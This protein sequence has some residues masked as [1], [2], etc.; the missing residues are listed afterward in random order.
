MDRLPIQFHPDARQEAL[1]AYSWY[2]ERSA[3]AAEAFRLELER[4]GKAIR[5][6]PNRWATY[7]HG[8]RC[9]LMKRYP[10]IV[11]YRTTTERIESVAIAH[12]RRK[13]G[14]WSSR[15]DGQ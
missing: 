8:T 5:D 12:R 14:Y 15:L 2:D 3:N 10:F 9:F 6:A 13:P 1:D 7:L 11:V 4:A